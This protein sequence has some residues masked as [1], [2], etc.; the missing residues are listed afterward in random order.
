MR[1]ERDESLTTRPAGVD[2]LRPR[3]VRERRNCSRAGEQRPKAALLYPLRDW[4]SGKLR[5]SGR[6]RVGESCR[7]RWSGRRKSLWP[8][9]PRE[10]LLSGRRSIDA[11]GMRA[12]W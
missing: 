1:R 11:S 5:R 8:A 3:S 4:L 2:R 10:R 12:T 7:S 6:G 9:G